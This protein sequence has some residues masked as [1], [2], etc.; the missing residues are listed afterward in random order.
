VG[1]K[2]IRAYGI[3]GNLHTVALVGTDGS[4]D[5]CCLPHFDSPS[6]FASILD[7]AKGGH[8]KISAPDVKKADQIYIKDTAILETS[9]TTE[10]GKMI[11]TDFMPIRAATPVEGVEF[12]EIYR[13]IRCI[14]GE[15]PVKIE[16][17][18]RFNYARSPTDLETAPNGAIAKSPDEVLTL[19]TNVPLKLGNGS[20]VAEVKL[21]KGEEE[22]FI[23]RY[24]DKALH[25]AGTY[26]L[27]DRLEQTRNFWLNWV[28]ECKYGGLWRDQVLRS[29]ITIKLLFYNPTGAIVAAPTTS[30]PEEIGGSRNWDY[31]FTW[32]RDA[33]FTLD[34]LF[35]LG[36][37]DEAQSFMSWLKRTCIVC[38][39][40]LQVFLGIDAQKEVPEEE[41]AHLEGYRGSR[42]VRIGNAASDQVQLDVYGEVLNSAY[43][44]VEFGGSLPEEMW[45]LL[46][47]LVEFICQHWTEPDNGIWE[48]RGAPRHFLHSKILSWVAVDRGIKIAEK[49]SFKAD[50][51]RWKE[52]R[53]KI[54]DEVLS[55]G[56]SE[57]KRSFVQSYGSSEVD[58]SNFRIPLVQFLPADDQ[59]VQMTIDR[60]YKELGVDSLVYRY[61]GQDG[62]VGGEGA[63]NI[64]SF[65]L[66]DCLALSG[67]LK[68]AR[69]I[70]E[71]MLTYGNHLYLFSEETDPASGEMLG[72]FP[73][74]FTHIGLINSAVNLNRLLERKRLEEL[75]L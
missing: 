67:R 21:S 19:A 47:S 27:E 31:R 51:S 8:F 75:K 13:R 60:T 35:T 41:L 69:E 37:I 14:E 58:A 63:F 54:R 46:Q 5:W 32:L 36:Y 24:G 28:G 62:L 48:M 26:R 30:L 29:A 52:V 2:P 72:N 45:G 71:K 39:L 25:P 74:A 20:V 49:C 61:K 70:F 64:C 7:E 42:P 65:W 6:V 59:R 9:F 66:V 53:D 56:W 16:F 34:A 23:V 38:G 22:W 55:K 68:E 10:T 15:T 17:K 40:R 1:Y 18:P 73:Q 11:L 44:L 33:S 3:I 12:H 50:I 57:E 43:S 4:I